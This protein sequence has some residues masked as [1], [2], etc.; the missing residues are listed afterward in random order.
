LRG[1]VEEP[2][3][4]CVLEVRNRFRHDRVGDGKAI[5]RPRHAPGLRHGKKDM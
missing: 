2:D 4:E 3:A 1:A 5:R